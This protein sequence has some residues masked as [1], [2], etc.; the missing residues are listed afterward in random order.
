MLVAFLYALAGIEQG[1]GENGPIGKELPVSVTNTFDRFAELMGRFEFPFRQNLHEF[2]CKGLMRVFD[3]EVFRGL[4]V[5][6]YVESDF[7]VSFS[8]TVIV[9]PIGV[10]WFDTLAYYNRFFAMALLGVGR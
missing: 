9:G 6:I 4:A 5:L 1:V 2:V 3:N 8:D 10:E 7:R